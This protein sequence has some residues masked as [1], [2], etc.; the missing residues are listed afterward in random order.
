[1]NQKWN[2]FLETG[3]VADY[4]SYRAECSEELTENPSGEHRH[5]KV[6]GDRY[7]DVGVACGRV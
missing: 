6:D 7:G 2:H 5:G 1:M 3:A 4:L